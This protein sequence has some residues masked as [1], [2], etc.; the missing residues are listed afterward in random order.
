MS[1]IWNQNNLGEA[2]NCKVSYKFSAG[3]VRFNSQLIEEGDI[4]IAL[5]LANNSHI[6]I[7][8]ALHRGA[9]LVIARYLPQN[10]PENEKILLVDDTYQ[11]LRQMA[12]YKRDRSDAKFIAI[13]GSVG[14][15]TVK[16]LT[17]LALA[18]YGITFISYKNFN[19]EI[20]LYINLA[21]LAADTTYAVIEL[22]MNHQNEL[23]KLTHIVK[24]DIALITNIAAVHIENFSSID[25]IVA[26][27]AEI[28]ED[29]N[30]K[31]AILNADNEYFTDLELLA[32][33]N[34]I[35]DISAI[36]IN[37][38]EQIGHFFDI[39]KIEKQ[40]A[41]TIIYFNYQNQSYKLQLELVADE[42]IINYFLA[43]AVLAKLNLDINPAIKVLETYKSQPGRGEIKELIIN[44]KKI[45]VID[46]CYNASFNSIKAALNRFMKIKA[47]RKIAVLGD[48]GELGDQAREIHEQL[49]EP[50]LQSK[51]QQVIAI[52]KQMSY[53]YKSLDVNMQMEHFNDVSRVAEFIV[54]NC[55]DGD[56]YLFKAS[57]FMKFSKIIDELEK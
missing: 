15:T 16:E 51:I 10:L 22:G 7:E 39:Y 55:Q 50:L 41:Q 38:T 18:Q 17:G 34:N 5:E 36:A 37:N 52:G 56:A 40:D 28:F 3:Q 49:K 33:K 46:D 53:L 14:K 48:I 9:S 23:R 31:Q 11:A 8:D 32:I 57:N 19:N 13:T 20:G 43:L 42:L 25:G 26:A 27:K 54:E 44:G 45:L 21:S 29:D 30:T 24:P 4:F 47:K 35:H 2:L 1:E 12:N 6:Y